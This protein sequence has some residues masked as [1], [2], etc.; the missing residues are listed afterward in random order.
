M[1]SDTHHAALCVCL[2]EVVGSCL[3]ECRRLFSAGCVCVR[4]LSGVREGGGGMRALPWQRYADA[5]GRQAAVLSASLA[6]DEGSINVPRTCSFIR[7]LQK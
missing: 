6:A 7:I 2:G 3:R 4:R 1:L 5:T